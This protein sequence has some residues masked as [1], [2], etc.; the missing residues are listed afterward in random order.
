MAIRRDHMQRERSMAHQVK[1]WFGAEV[2]AAVAHPTGRS[3]TT[4]WLQIKAERDPTLADFWHQTDDAFLE[5]SILFLKSERDYIYLHHGAHLRGHVGFS[6]QGRSLSELR[7]RIRARLIDIY[8]RSAEAFTLGYLLSF[9]D[10]MHD[11]VLWGRLVLPLRLSAADSRVALLVYCQPIADKPMILRTLFERTHASTI[12]ATPIKD[13]SGTIVD[14]WI[15]A[16]NDEARRFTG[17]VEHATGDL[18]LRHI[19]LFARDDLWGYLM[20]RLPLEVAT[21]TVSD[22]SKGETINLQV[23]SLE[24]YI[25][26][27]AM[28]IADT[29][30]VF[31]IE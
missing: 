25:V 21:A 22:R 24:D 18:L 6:M 15:V 4:K 14:G 10:F 16:L 1:S 2:P 8:D 26:I 31:L 19:P 23:E 29:G 9:A 12:I 11:V 28:P 17:V 5:R 13:E 3:L 30:D 7:T 27:R 20:E